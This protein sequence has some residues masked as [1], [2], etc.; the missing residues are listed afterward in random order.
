MERKARG[1]LTGG[2]CSYPAWVLLDLLTYQR[3]SRRCLGPPPS[4]PPPPRNPPPPGRP[5]PPPLVFGRAS[6]T[7]RARP[8]TF[9]PF[10]AVMARSASSASVISTNAK[11][12]DR[13]VSR[14]VIRLT[15][16]TVPYASNSER[17][18]SSVAPK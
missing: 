15:R 12:R 9:E 17:M 6:L 18:V 16:S 5:P 10:N 14:S 7:L 3:G 2:Q 11:P 13:P 4:R 1:A 8:P